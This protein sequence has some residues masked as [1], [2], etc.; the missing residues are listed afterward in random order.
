MPLIKVKNPRKRYAFVT[1][2]P[3]LK[4]GR[5]KIRIKITLQI[6]VKTLKILFTRPVS[7]LGTRL[8]K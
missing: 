3:S 7:L 6:V 5:R 2:D 8:N 1:L 4:N